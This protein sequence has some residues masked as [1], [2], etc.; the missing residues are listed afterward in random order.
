MRN[1]FLQ[2]RLEGDF[3]CCLLRFEEETP[4]TLS[5]RPPDAFLIENK[6]GKLRHETKE[7]KIAY[8]TNGKKV[9]SSD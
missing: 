3:E 2:I 7:T 4:G 1:Y 9:A 6:S 5:Q 8:Q